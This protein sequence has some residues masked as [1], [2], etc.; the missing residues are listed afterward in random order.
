MNII[1][2]TPHDINILSDARM[3]LLT[4][5]ASGDTIRLAMTT[6]RLDP[7]DG[8]PISKTVFGEP[9]GLPSPDYGT[10]YIV[11]GLVKSALPDR[12]DLLVPSEIVRDENGRI[13]GCQSLG[14]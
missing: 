11:S 4:F 7:L 3:P 1:N 2:M 10:F 8:V 14:I 12:P 5:L 13:V 6:E 9:E